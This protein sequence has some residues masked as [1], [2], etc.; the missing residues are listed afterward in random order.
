M[1]QLGPDDA[2]LLG[3]F[4][5]HTPT[6]EQAACILKVRD[7][8]KAAALV[9][10][11]STPPSADRTAA[12]RQLHEAMMTANKAIVLTGWRFNPPLGEP[13][14]RGD[15]EELREYPCNCET[16]RAPR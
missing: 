9:V 2:K 1:H 7:A 13:G 11:R 10:L 5:H 12:L 16:C 15:I 8:F 4:D 3:T 6:A 14:H